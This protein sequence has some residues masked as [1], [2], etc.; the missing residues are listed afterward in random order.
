MDAT[1]LLKG[2]RLVPVVVI[3]DAATAVP[4]ARALG[5]AGLHA[6][7]VTLRTDAALDAMERIAHE[8]PDALVGAGSVRQPEQLRAARAAGAVFCVSPGFTE[9]LLT[10]A[11]DA[12]MPF[13]PGAVTATESMHLLER[14]YTLQKF[15]PAELAGGLKMIRA[16]S[17]PLPEVRYFPTGGITEKTLPEYLAQ[18]NV[19]A[20]GGSWLAPGALLQQGDYAAI[21]EFARRAV[22]LLNA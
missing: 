6:I 9:S 19:A 18:P 14:G 15:F 11:T 17:A 1:E 3:E 5:D 7:E 13:V 10:A 12:Q 21:G 20:I 16:L 22:A 8:V 2:Q 4:L